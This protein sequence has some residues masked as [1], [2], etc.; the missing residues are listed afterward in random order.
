MVRTTQNDEI[1]LAIIKKYIVGQLFSLILGHTIYKLMLS[2]V[3]NNSNSVSTKGENSN[4]LKTLVP[5]D[6]AAQ[7]TPNVKSNN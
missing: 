3:R 1:L 5:V 6:Q 4:I 2:S 7:Y